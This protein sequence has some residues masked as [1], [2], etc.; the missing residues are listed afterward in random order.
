MMKKILT[1]LLAAALTAALAACGG[2]GVTGSDPAGSTNEVQNTAPDGTSEIPDPVTDQDISAAET[3]E[4]F[5]LTTEDGTFTQNGSVY[6]ITAAGSYTLT[7]RLE[8]QILVEAGEED[9]VELILNGTT[10]SCG[11]DSPLK[12]LSAKKAEISVKKD[13]DNVILDTRSTKTAD[14]DSQG[15]GAIYAKCDLKLKGAGTLVVTAGYNNGIHTTKDLTIQKLSLKVSAYNNAIKGNDSV[16]I[17]GGNVVA[18]STNGDGIKTQNTDANKKGVTRGDITISGGAVTVYAAGDGFQAAHDFEMAAD[19]EGNTPKVTVYL[20]TYNQEKYIR[21]AL[22]SIFM[23]ETSFPFEVVVADD[24]STD[25][26][27]EIILEYQKRC[28][29]VLTTYFTPENV[30]NCRKTVNCF[31]LGL[32]AGNMFRCSRETIT[33][34][35]RTGSRCSWISSTTIPDMC[36][37]AT[38]NTSSIWT[39]TIWEQRRTLLSGVKSL[40]SGSS[41][42]ERA[43]RITPAY[44]ATFTGKTA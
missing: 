39:G 33:G 6:T 31:E 29:D 13:T 4:A 37:S 23:Q 14:T 27:R 2:P 5:S 38:R 17:T 26:T 3:T 22:D 32:F 18:I 20:S 41:S 40:R 35:K 11:T 19:A 43:T 16:E 36:S 34:W 25:G 28:P 42:T 1:I 24:F 44:S 15:E 21:K 9:E 12:I 10:L 7:G 30:G 8:G